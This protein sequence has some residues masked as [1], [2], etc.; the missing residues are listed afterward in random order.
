L[1]IQAAI[2]ELE[3]VVDKASSLALRLDANL[4]AAGLE[5][6]PPLCLHFQD[7]GHYY[8]YLLPSH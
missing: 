8:R 7:P 6:A 1:D 2:A 4:F 5:P 3:G